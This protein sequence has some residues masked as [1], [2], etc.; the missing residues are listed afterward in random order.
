MA[1]RIS[2]AILGRALRPQHTP[3]IPRA[4]SRFYSTSPDAEK[5]PSIVGEFYKTFTRPVLK[6]LLMATLTYQIAYWSWTKLEQDEIRAEK[7]REIEG[8][9]TRVAELQ[10]ADKRTRA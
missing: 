4:A 9:E 6:V 8:L 10:A 7:G 3:H 5:R 2:T 1:A